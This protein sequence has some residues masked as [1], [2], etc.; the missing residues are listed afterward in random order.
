MLS[1]ATKPTPTQPF[2]IIQRMEWR[3]LREHKGAKSLLIEGYACA[4]MGALTGGQVGLVK[5]GS[6][7]IG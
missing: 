3:D 4:N 1:P 5:E 6:T 7:Y 2:F